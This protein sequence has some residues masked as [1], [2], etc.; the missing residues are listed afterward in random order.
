MIVNV[1]LV[2]MIGCLLAYFSVCL[3]LYDSHPIIRP[4]QFQ[5]HN[6]NFTKATNYTPARC[7]LKLAQLW[8]GHLL[9][10]GN[11]KPPVGS[12]PYHALP[13]STCLATALACQLKRDPSI[14]DLL[15]S[16]FPLNVYSRAV[17]SHK[18]DFQ[19]HLYIKL[20]VY[21]L[22]VSIPEEYNTWKFTSYPSS[23][24]QQASA[25]ALVP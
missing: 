23:F 3:F 12:H 5:N 22:L 21:T 13:V 1:C 19:I 14:A 4:G 9:R 15:S 11:P 24:S 18:N 2:W 6:A 10:K 7:E 8:Q 16:Q 20:S 17:L 25:F